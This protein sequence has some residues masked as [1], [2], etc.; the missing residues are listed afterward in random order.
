MVCPVY[1]WFRSGVRHQPDIL[2]CPCSIIILMEHPF[3]SKDIFPMANALK[4]PVPGHALRLLVARAPHVAPAGHPST[5]T[6]SK[7]EPRTW[8][9]RC[10][11]F[12]MRGD[13]LP[14][15]GLQPGNWWHSFAIE[16]RPF[17]IGLPTMVILPYVSCQRVIMAFFGR[18]PAGELWQK[19]GIPYFKIGLFLL[20]SLVL[21][22]GWK[23]P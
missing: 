5:E 3:W 11:C 2:N 15:L 23:I 10:V 14:T 17:D 20:Y 19:M 4:Q 18:I 16:N 21:K 12:N 13:K 7:S 6:W 8:C 1:V 9:W 22:L